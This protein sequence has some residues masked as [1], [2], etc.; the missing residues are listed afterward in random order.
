MYQ[1]KTTLRPGQTARIV[2]S[3]ALLLALTSCSSIMT[4]MMAP[5]VDNLQKQTDVDLVCQG[6][7]SYLLMIDSMIAADQ[8]NSALLAM[9]AKSYSAYVAAMTE[10][11]A[12]EERI[13]A[14]A[15]KA[16]LYGTAL[17]TARIRTQHGSPASIADSVKVERIMLR[18]EELDD[19]YQQGGV[20]LFLGAYYA[21]KPQMF[22]GRPDLS[23]I[24]FEKALAISQRSFLLVQTTYAD[25]YARQ[26]RDKALFDGLLKEVVD[27]PLNNSKDNALSNQIAKRKA[28]R[29]LADA[30][31]AEEELPNDNQQ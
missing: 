27:F 24:E 20:H 21:A 26:V 23:R 1:R 19:T 29:L 6:A 14:L 9:G 13:Q 25:T 16:R 22:G 12:G 3:L 30:P 8:D 5:T 31:F 28:K 7:P 11:G 2:L 4:G 10:C 18:L 15:D 17:L